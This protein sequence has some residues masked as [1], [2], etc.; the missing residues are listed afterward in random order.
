MGT[1]VVIPTL[2]PD[3]DEVTLLEWIVDDGVRVEA[4]EV[5]YRVETDKAETDCE[6]PAPG[7]VRHGA[8]P[9]VVYPAGTVIGEIQ[10]E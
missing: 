10:G 1:P 3:S 4:G 7:I 5:L 9:G 2:G 8:S 6:A